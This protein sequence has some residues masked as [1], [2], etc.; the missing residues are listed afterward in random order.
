LDR[1]FQLRETT[2][3]SK[4]GNDRLVRFLQVAGVLVVL[5]AGFWLRSLSLGKIPLRSSDWWPWGR[6][7]TVTLYFSDGQSLFPVSR[8][9]P[10]NTELPNAVLRALFAGPDVRSSLKS[11]IPSGTEIRS[12]NIS[13]ATANIDLSSAF[14]AASS[15]L[16]LAKAAIIETMT[17]LPDVSSV[18]LSVEGKPVSTPATRRPLLYYGS[19]NG[20]VALP[21]SASGPRAAL[22]AY[23]S[24]PSDPELTGFPHDVQLLKYEYAEANRSL[25]LNFTYTP[26]I[27]TLALDKP[28]RMRLVLLG[29][30]ATLTEFPEVRTLQIDFQGQTRLGLGQCS[31]LLRTPQA[32]PQLLN[33][34]R[35]LE[36]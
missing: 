35:L 25:S 26:S 11:W 1:P 20:L 5:G 32:R 29:L 17:A 13:G 15:R 24:G 19:A 27:R 34:E 6:T 12:F 21:A 22:E 14:L 31:D 8:R 7:A 23:L 30:I 33:D 3:N 9:M 16:D 4:M 28:E 18:A 2:A 36:R 10:V